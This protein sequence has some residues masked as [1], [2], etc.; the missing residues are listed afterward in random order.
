MQVYPRNKASSTSGDTLPAETKNE[1]DMILKYKEQKGI[2]IMMNND[3]IALENKEKRM[4][5]RS[6]GAHRFA[7]GV[8][9]GVAA[10]V[11]ARIGFATKTRKETQDMKNRCSRENTSSK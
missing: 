2:F 9:I 1:I 11:A 8:I 3:S 10:A 6:K 4:Q 7:A 5:A